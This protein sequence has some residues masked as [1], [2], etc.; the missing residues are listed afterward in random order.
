M[1]AQA[2]PKPDWRSFVNLVDDVATMVRYGGTY[3][4]TM[5]PYASNL[6]VE[7]VAP[8]PSVNKSLMIVAGIAGVAVLVLIL[9]R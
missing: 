7:P 8:S 6:T 9:G 2:K 4:L 1:T 5:D 3:Q